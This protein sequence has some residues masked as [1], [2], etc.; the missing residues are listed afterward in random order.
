MFLFVLKS[1][2]GTSAR[3][4]VGAL[5]DFPEEPPGPVEVAALAALLHVVLVAGDE[6]LRGEHVVQLSV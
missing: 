4:I 3:Q 5:P 6:V 1:S 2:C